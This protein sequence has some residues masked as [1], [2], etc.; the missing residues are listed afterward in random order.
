MLG[1]IAKLTI[2]PGSNADFEA[3]MKALQAKVRALSAE[4][5]ASAGVLASLPFVVMILVYITT[6]AY[7]VSQT[8]TAVTLSV[9]ATDPGGAASL[10]YTWTVTG[11]A[12]VT[13]NGGNVGQTVTDNF[14]PRSHW[15]KSPPAIAPGTASI[16]SAASARSWY[17]K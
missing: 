9:Q 8:S 14:S 3:T 16:M 15:K 13:F 2:K 12:G 7:I 5:K 17:V 10:T 4:A 6:P 1:V 11:P